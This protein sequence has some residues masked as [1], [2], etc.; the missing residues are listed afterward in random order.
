M[1]HRAMQLNEGLSFIGDRRTYLPVLG[2]S[3]FGQGPG[4]MS[5]FAAI[6]EMMMSSICS[7]RN[8]K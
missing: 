3:P 5:E 1:P 7:C 6:Y 8:K 4:D 2:V